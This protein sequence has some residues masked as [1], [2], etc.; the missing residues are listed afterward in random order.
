MKKIFF[1]IICVMMVLMMTTGLSLARKGEGPGKA[2]GAV[3]DIFS[4]EKFTFTGVVTG[5]IPGHGIEIDTGKE[6]VTVYGIG[7]KRYW[8]ELEVERPEVGDD[9][10]VDGYTVSPFGEVR[11]IAV[12]ITI[13]VEY[14]EIEV[15]L[16]DLDTGVPLW[17]NNR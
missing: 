8:N 10:S 7:P 13:A 15:E 6:V 17:Y 12:I 4:G 16:R 5:M 14:D 3:Y 2:A 1:I 11:H 9:V